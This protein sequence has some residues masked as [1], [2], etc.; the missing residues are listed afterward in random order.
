MIFEENLDE[1]LSVAWIR[2]H[3]PSVIVGDLG[4]IPLIPLPNHDRCAG[5]W[6]LGIDR[7]HQGTT[8]I[9][10][11]GR[12]P[13]SVGHRQIAVIQTQRELIRLYEHLV[14]EGSWVKQRT[15]L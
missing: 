12:P 8:C 7:K 14:G 11:C 10:Y 9:I 4:T 15:V 13:K 6:Y 2:K 3:A 5:E 1:K